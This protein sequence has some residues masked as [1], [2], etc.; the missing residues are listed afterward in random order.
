MAILKNMIDNAKLKAEYK[1]VDAYVNEDLCDCSKNS[2]Y[3]MGRNC[4][5]FIC[6]PEDALDVLPEY[7]INFK[8]AKQAN[9]FI[10]SNLYDDPYNVEMMV[11]GTKLVIK[12]TEAEY[13]AHFQVDDIELSRELVKN[14]RRQYAQSN[15]FRIPPAKTKKRVER[16]SQET[17][18]LGLEL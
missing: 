16:S 9:E 2:Y 10:L 6:N 12:P 11:V 1:E 15:G 5:V 14:F 8:T 7:S 3:F 17:D 4:D 18:W 13:E